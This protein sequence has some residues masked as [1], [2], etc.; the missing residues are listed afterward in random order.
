MAGYLLRKRGGRMAYIK[1]MK[2]LYLADRDFLVSFG[3]SMSGDNYVSMD[4]GPVLSKTYDLVKPG[5]KKADFW[6]T[7]IARESR[8]EVA[9][10]NELDAN[11]DAFDELSKAEIKTLDK[12]F[13]AYGDLKRFEICELTHSL[14]SEWQDPQGSSSPIL[15]KDILIAGGKTDQ[16]ADEIV[17]HIQERDALQEFSTQLS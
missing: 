6:S 5:S 7:W 15:I 12:I 1:L 11:D 10:K 16:E 2:L 4:N 13:S 9:L 17:Q 14:C 3:R 8:W